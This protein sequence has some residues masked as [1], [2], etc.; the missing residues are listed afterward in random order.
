VVGRCY[1]YPKSET[2]ALF[3]LHSLF[4]SLPPVTTVLMVHPVYML[5]LFKLPHKRLLK[6]FIL[7]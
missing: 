3:L 4:G 7:K 6:L 2:T 1:N 5:V